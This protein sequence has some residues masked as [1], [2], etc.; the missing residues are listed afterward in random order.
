[1]LMEND[2]ELVWSA[3]MGLATPDDQLACQ[4]HAATRG[5]AK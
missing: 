5:S 4:M 1:M 2:Q 3:G